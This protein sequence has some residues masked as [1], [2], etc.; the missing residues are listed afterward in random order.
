[1]EYRY[2]TQDFTHLFDKGKRIGSPVIQRGSTCFGWCVFPSASQPLWD[3]SL[4]LPDLAENRMEKPRS[5][6]EKV[7]LESEQR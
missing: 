4:E 7:R 3:E 1:M 2:I 5:K 6:K